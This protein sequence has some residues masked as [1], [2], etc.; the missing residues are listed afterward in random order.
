MTTRCRS[1]ATAAYTFTSEASVSR[2]VVSNGWPR[3]RATY[4][5]VSPA[6]SATSA[7]PAS[8]TVSR[9]SGF[10]AYTRM[11]KPAPNRSTSEPSRSASRAATT[12][13]HIVNRSRANTTS[14]MAT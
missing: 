4:A 14:F 2:T 10:H 8:G 12:I 3:R 6:A 11:P 13:I 9:I 7:R 5:A 1:S